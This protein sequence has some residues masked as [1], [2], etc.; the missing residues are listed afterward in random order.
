MRRGRAGASVLRWGEAQLRLGPSPGAGTR[1]WSRDAE[2]GPAGGLPAQGSRARR[3]RPRPPGPPGG[4]TRRFTEAGRVVGGAAPAPDSPSR[5]FCHIFRGLFL[6]LAAISSS[7]GATE[8][9]AAE[10]APLF[11]P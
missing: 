2:E 6:I 7:G 8:R 10:E 5:S 1:P 11:Q 4:A 3:S 9:L